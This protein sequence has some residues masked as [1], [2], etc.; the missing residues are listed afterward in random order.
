MNRKI[1]EYCQSPMIFVKCIECK[2]I[3]PITINLSFCAETMQFKVE[4]PK[5]KNYCDI[6]RTNANAIDSATFL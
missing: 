6:E 4:N 3:H 2:S 1:S 5:F